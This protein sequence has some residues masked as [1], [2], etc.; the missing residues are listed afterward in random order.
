MLPVE[1]DIEKTDDLQARIKEKLE[2][3]KSI[4]KEKSTKKGS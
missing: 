3:L 1:P 2:V 4:R